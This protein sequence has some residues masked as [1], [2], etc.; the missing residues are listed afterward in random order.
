METDFFSKLRRALARPMDPAGLAAFRVLFGLTMMLAV[1]RFVVN[2]W[3]SELLVLPGYHFTYLGFDWVRPLPQPLMLIAFG[4]MGLCALSVAIGLF[5]RLS[6]AIFCVL[7][8]YAE[9]IDKATYLNHYYLVTLLALLL[10]FVPSGTAWSVDAWRRARAGRTTTASVP[11]LSYLVL[12]AQV[13]VVYV[14]AGLAKLDGDWLVRAEPLKTWLRARVESPILAGLVAEPWVPHA[15]SWAGAAF[16]L[17][18]V[19]LLCVRRTRP[20]AFAAAV[21]FHLSIWLLFP[22]GVFSFVMLVAVTVFFEPNWPRR[23]LGRLVR[24]APH[25]PAAPF[26][27]PRPLA[28]GF[29]LAFVAVQVMV[30]LRFAL[31]PGSVNWTEQGFRFAWRVMLIEKSGRVEYDVTTSAGRFRVFPRDELTPLQLRQMATQPDMIEQ[32]AHHLRRRFEADGYQ[33]VRVRADAWVAFNGRRSQR[34]I[35][36]KVDLAATER[37]F[38]PKPWILPLDERAPP[39]LAHR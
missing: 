7:F 31:Y 11:A 24:L 30:P 21:L 15:M 1:A 39:R 27:S 13:G 25:D 14:F 29:A 20:F 5:T 12:R 23:F 4:V 37:S 9:L 34:L 35:D 19:P 16:D 22:V 18:I 17:A 26:P 10:V 2:G 38:A 6:A 32:Y 36:P 8:T 33:N 28:F 3:V